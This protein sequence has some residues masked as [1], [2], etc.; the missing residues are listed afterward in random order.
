VS[1]QSVSGGSKRGLVIGMAVVGLIALIVGI[2]WVTGHAP[3]FL[4]SGS[5][6]KAKNGGHLFRGAAA[7]V[8]AVA[9]F[10]GAWITNRK[11]AAPPANS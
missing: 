5:H 2:L 7:F 1:S 10:V 6:V 11:T 8:V 3:S 4:D 9:L